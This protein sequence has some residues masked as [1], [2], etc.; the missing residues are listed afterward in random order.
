M[1][2]ALWAMVVASLLGAIVSAMRPAH[3]PS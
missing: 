3:R 1:H 2:A